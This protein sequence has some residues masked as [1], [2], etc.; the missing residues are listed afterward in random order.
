MRYL[1]LLCMLLF[2]RPAVTEK[3]VILKGC[4]LRVAGSTNINHFVCSVD[5]YSSPDTLLLCK[6]PGGVFMQ[7]CLQLPVDHFD[8]GNTAM[9]DDLRKTLQEKAYPLMQIRFLSLEKYP[10]LKTTPENI[11][12]TVCIELAGVSRK[13]QVDY[14]VV[15]DAQQVLHLTGTQHIRFSDFNLIPPKKLGGMIRANDELDVIFY[16]NFRVIPG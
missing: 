13:M 7:G 16:I 5:Q 2:S 4:T 11:I 8:C 9:T 12:G 15:M 14:Q 3:W 1:A 10:D 6:N